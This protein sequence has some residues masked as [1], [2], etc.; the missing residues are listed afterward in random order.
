M[1][2]HHTLRIAYFL[3]PFSFFLV[4]SCEVDRSSI[5][6][7]YPAEKNYYHINDYDYIKNRYFFID[8]YYRDRYEKGYSDDLMLWTYEKGT[9]IRELNVY[10]TGYLPNTP[11]RKGVATI[12]SRIKEYEN[13]PN[14]D[15]VE[16]YPGE[17][18]KGLFAPLNE[19]T[20]YQY[21]YAQ[22]Y[23]WLKWPVKPTEILAVSYRTDNDTIGTLQSMISNDDSTQ[24]YVLR[25]I[26]STGRG[27]NP[28]VWPL[29]MRNV[30]FLGDSNYV[31]EGFNINILKKENESTVQEV[32][33]KKSFAHLLGLDLTDENGAVIDNG[34]GQVDNNYYL[35]NRHTGILMFPGIQPF[36]PLDDSRFQIADTNRVNQYNTPDSQEM[37]ASS[38][39]KIIVQYIK[40]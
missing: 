9:L 14:I 17:V 39:F 18:E 19:G 26:K 36:D 12:P 30:Y 1:K 29:M 38:K 10:H 33:P 15:G 6:A 11:A 40:K 4:F 13:L 5:G 35:C 25:L 7:E 37:I 21:N 2:R 8:Q 23:F 28:N 31:R 27:Y 34:D 24:F 32:E 3:I 16:S 20:D 22:G